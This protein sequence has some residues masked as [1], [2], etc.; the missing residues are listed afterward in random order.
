[1][2]DF[3][4]HPLSSFWLHQIAEQAVL[5]IPRAFAPRVS[6]ILAQGYIR[7]VSED[8]QALM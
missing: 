7:R 3:Q 2:A 1:L 6:H 4:A 8:R 5:Y